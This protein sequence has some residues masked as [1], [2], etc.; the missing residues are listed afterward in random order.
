MFFGFIA[1][2]FSI[3]YAD[4]KQEIKASCPNG[5]NPESSLVR[6]VVLKKDNGDDDSYT[7]FEMRTVDTMGKCFRI[8]TTRFVYLVDEKRAIFRVFIDYYSKP[9]LLIDF[10]NSKAKYRSFVGI[11]KGIGLFEYKDGQGIPRKI[12]HVLV[13]H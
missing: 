8:S 7:A 6:K 3:S 1:L 11:V 9:L 10:D 12:P 2:F 4:P 13:V 5:I